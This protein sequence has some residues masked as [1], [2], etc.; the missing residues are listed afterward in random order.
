MST[1]TKPYLIRALHEWCSD[2]GYSPYVVVAVRDEY[3]QVPMEYVKNQEIV[4]D[5]GFD[6]TKNLLLRNDYISFFARFNGISR[7]IIIPVGAVLSIFAKETGNGMGFEYEEPN[8]ALSTPSSGF[9]GGLSL[10][11]D[12]EDED[13]DDEPEPP[14][15]P[16]GKPKLSIVE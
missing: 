14:H 5:I 7:E 9:Q 2:N 4:L 13:G 8:E 10:V 3:T 12:K 6:A 15:P 16:A 1:S 11:S